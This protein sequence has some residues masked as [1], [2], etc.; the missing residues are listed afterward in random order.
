VKSLAVIPARYAS[1]RFP[2][3][4]LAILSGKPMIQHV[5]ERCRAADGVD[6]VIVAT[7]DE[8]I[9]N[10]CHAFGAECEMT[11][12]EHHSGTDRVAE[13]AQRYPE[14]EIVLN[15]QG[16]EPAMASSTIAAVV[17][18]L[19]KDQCVIATPVTIARP[20]DLPNPN[21]VKVVVALTG[22]A[23]YFSRAAIPFHRDGLPSTR[24]EYVRHIGLYGFR[25]EALLKVTQLPVLPLE[26]AESL[27]QLRWLQAGWKIRCVAVSSLSIGV[28]TPEDLKSL[29]AHWPNPS[30]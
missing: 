19:R 4:P 25:R 16:D 8:R 28:D 11:S 17:S 23:L 10:A 27:E 9:V 22:D 24:P 13:V 3:K 2:G 14:Y 29:E 7:E 6:R 1:T 26:V 18:V 20:D 30:R 12:A 15:V 21:V 5:W